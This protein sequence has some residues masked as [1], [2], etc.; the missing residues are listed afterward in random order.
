MPDVH[1]A[2]AGCVSGSLASFSGKF[3]LMIGTCGRSQPATGRGGS[4]GVKPAE[5]TDTASPC[6]ASRVVSSRPVLP[7][8]RFNV[9]LWQG[10][11]GSAKRLVQASGVDPRV[12]IHGFAPRS[13]SEDTARG[14]RHIQEG[15]TFSS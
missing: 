3:P 6:Y 1:R 2:R 9:G 13:V 8:A 5:K 4:L 10:Q 14:R 12:T 7:P 11:C 15:G